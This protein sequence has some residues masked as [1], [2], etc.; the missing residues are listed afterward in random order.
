MSRTWPRA[1]MHP[2]MDLPTVP[3]S[4]MPAKVVDESGEVFRE[5]HPVAVHCASAVEGFRDFDE[6]APRVSI[7]PIARLAGE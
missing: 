2:A 4:S 6:V 3:R 7:V 1:S 5:S